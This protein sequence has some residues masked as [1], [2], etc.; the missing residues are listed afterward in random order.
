LRLPSSAAGA[1]RP[2][3]EIRSMFVVMS[4]FPWLHLRAGFRIH[5]TRHAKI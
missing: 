2:W 4:A 5:R 1:L 3:V